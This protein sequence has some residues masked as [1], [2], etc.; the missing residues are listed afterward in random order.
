MSI[1]FSVC[2]AIWISP[3]CMLL[4]G[5]S[6]LDSDP[7]WSSVHKPVVSR[8][9]SDLCLCRSEVSP[10]VHPQ[11]SGTVLLISVLSAISLILSSSLGLPVPILW[12]KSW[13]FGFS[14]LLGIS[15]Y[16]SGP[17]IREQRKKKAESICLT[18][19]GPQLLWWER[20]VLLPQS[21]KC[22]PTHC[23]CHCAAVATT[24]MVLP[25]FGRRREEKEKQQGIR[26]CL[27]LRSPF[28]A[29]QTCNRGHQE[30]FFQFTLDVHS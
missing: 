13:G 3:V 29:P 30:E 16:V 7:T 23:S 2:G 9:G 1:S 11:L 18:L 14:T 4:S 10:W 21:F 28:P 27:T 20:R 8:L 5:Q 24:T 19:L 12:P 17:S 22:L 6:D 15:Y 26:C 25:G